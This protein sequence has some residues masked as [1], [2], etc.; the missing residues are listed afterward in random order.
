MLYVCTIDGRRRSEQ[1]LRLFRCHYERRR[2]KVT[3]SGL[4][5]CVTNNTKTD[6]NGGID[7]DFSIVKKEND[8]WSPVEEIGDRTTNTETYIFQG[9]RD[10]NIYWSEIY[11]PLSAR[12]YPLYFQG[13]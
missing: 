2:G 4:T 11:E 10:L 9:E 12:A 5:V 7:D 1:K 3:S 13:R 8:E 6:I